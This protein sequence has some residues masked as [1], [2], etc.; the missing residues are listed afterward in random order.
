MFFPSR[1]V[2]Y[3]TSMHPSTRFIEVVNS[4]VVIYKIFILGYGIGHICGAVLKEDE[5]MHLHHI[6]LMR[7]GFSE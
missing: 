7:V 6:L 2:S 5:C 4:V 3:N 1:S